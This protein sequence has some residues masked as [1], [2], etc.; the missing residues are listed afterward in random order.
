MRQCFSKLDRKRKCEEVTR[1]IRR[2]R[3]TAEMKRIGAV[4]GTQERS[5]G[6]GAWAW[7]RPGGLY[8]MMVNDFMAIQ[9]KV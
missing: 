9:Y 8:E 1:F 2:G 5:A 6:Y 7:N 4:S 3:G